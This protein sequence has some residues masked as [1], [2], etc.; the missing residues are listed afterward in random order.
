MPVVAS[1]DRTAGRMPLTIYSDDANDDGRPDALIAEA[2]A[3]YNEAEKCWV[4]VIDWQAIRHAS[5]ERTP[6]T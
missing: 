3:H 4:A 2:I 1:G 6:A 5:D